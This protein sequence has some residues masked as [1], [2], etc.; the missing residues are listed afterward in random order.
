MIFDTHIH[1]NDDA[2]YSDVENYIKI[3]ENAG[4]AAFL[5]VG[6]DIESSKKAV[7]LAHRF[8][9]VY[10]AIGVHPTEFKDLN[11]DYVGEI[12]KLIDDRVVAIG[13]IGL[14]YHWDTVARDVQKEYFAKFIKLAYKHKLPISLHV[15]DAIEDSYNVLN[16]NREFLTKG[17]MHCYSG[18]AEMMGKFIDLGMYIALGGTVTFLNAKKVH[19]VAA[20]VPLD[21]L[22][23]ETDAPYLAPHPFRG[24]MNRPEYIVKV[25]ENIGAIRDLERFLVEKITFEN[26]EKLFNVV[27]KNNN[28][29][30]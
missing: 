10:A 29:K 19:E 27:V 5:C 22:V 4:V 7:E 25:V 28:E 23:V 6:Y 30:D 1:L 26:A 9:N 8:N 18:S 14:D 13:E 12:E 21:K 11:I 2:F 3:A 24:Q 20:K 15:R 17:V 16:E